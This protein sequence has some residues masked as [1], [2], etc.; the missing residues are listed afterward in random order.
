[1]RRFEMREVGPRKLAQLFLIRALALLE[2]NKSVWR[3]APAFMRQSDDRDLL[4]RWM[5]QK[6]ASGA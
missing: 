2:H 3:L 5:P 6:H 4:Y 1:M